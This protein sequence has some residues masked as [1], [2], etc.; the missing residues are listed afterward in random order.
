MAIN[1]S[2]KIDSL[3]LILKWEIKKTS[4][5]LLSATVLQHLDPFYNHYI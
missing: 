2:R 5:P 4:F 1:D 3:V